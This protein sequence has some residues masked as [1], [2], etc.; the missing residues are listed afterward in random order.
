MYTRFSRYKNILKLVS[1][2]TIHNFQFHIKCEY[3]I[4]K[5]YYVI[6]THQ[7]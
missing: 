6:P 1:L 2:K 5:P 4:L 3:K 7:V